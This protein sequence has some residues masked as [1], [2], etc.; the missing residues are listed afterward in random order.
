MQLHVWGPFGDLPSFDPE[1]LALV[2]FFKK[3]NVE[4]EV[5]ASN[6]KFLS[7]TQTLPVL[8]DTNKCLVANGFVE[9]CYWLKLHDYIEC[10]SAQDVALAAYAESL[11]TLSLYTLF[12][13]RENYEKVTR[14]RISSA[15]AFPMQ[16]NAAISLQRQ[17]RRRCD[18]SQLIKTNVKVTEK[19]KSLGKTHEKL[20]ES[21]RARQVALKNSQKTLQIMSKAKT[22]WTIA[23]EFLKKNFSSELDLKHPSL[24]LLMANIRLSTLDSLVEVPVKDAIQEHDVLKHLGSI[25]HESVRFSSD[26]DLSYNLYNYLQSWTPWTTWS[27]QAAS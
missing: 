19:D 26:Q 8:L 2:W 7:P 5:V 15:V 6:N 3:N 1:C 9:I 18:W 24:F 22:E 10:D 20:V 17:V 16:Y 13:I 23:A 25:S 11:S 12:E 27:V 21:T 4:I 14:P